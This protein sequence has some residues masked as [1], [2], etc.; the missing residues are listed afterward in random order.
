[1]T[2]NF[3]RAI[4]LLTTL[5]S[6]TALSATTYTFTKI[7]DN[8]AGPFNLMAFQTYILNGNGAV[9]FSIGSEGGGIYIGSGGDVATVAAGAPTYYILTGFN[10]SGTVVYQASGSITTNTANGTPFKVAPDGSGT[11]LPAINNN[12]TVVFTTMDNTVM[13]R[14]GSAA[15]QTLVSNTALPR[16]NQLLAPILYGLGINSAGTVAF[17]GTNVASE[18]SC[19]CGLVLVAP[20][21]NPV[22][23]S[24]K[25]NVTENT[26]LNDSGAVA[27]M[28]IYNGAKG[29]FVAQN[30]QVGAAVD[31]TSQ[32]VSLA[33]QYVSLNNKGEVAYFAKFDISP[34]TQ[35]IFTG[36]DK[37]NDKVIA[38]GDPLF[39]SVVSSIGTSEFGGRFLNDKGQIAFSYVLSNGLRG[40]AVAT[41]VASTTPPPAIS[42]GGIVN[43]ASFASGAPASPGSIVSIFGSNFISQLAVAPGDPL[44]TSLGGVSVT[45]NGTKAPLFFVAPGQI[46]AQVPFEVTGTSATVQVTNAAGQSNTQVIDMAP[47]APAIFTTD[48][49]GIGQAVVVFANSVTIVGPV[50]PGTDWRPAH[51]GDTI[52]IYTNGMGAVTPPINDGWNSCDKSMCAPDFSNLTLRNTSVRPKVTIGGVTVPDSAILY[53]GLVPEFAGLYQINVTIPSGITPGDNVP[54]VIQM[55]D[56]ASP[57]NV[58]IGLQ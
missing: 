11:S 27:F 19:N 55:G 35:G 36:P 31:L 28:G 39:G 58:H 25:Q 38:N 9:A 46:N 16:A 51:T 15:A 18:T 32:L 12:G 40:I 22:L 45:F 10:D 47:A 17:Y 20:G 43:A 3:V 57:P 29:V 44:P 30:G 26:E 37:V 4:V 33:T 6:G 49:N 5:F 2:G 23:T 53:S 34:F 8:G 7:V 21:S 50:K 24:F 56:V 14:T 41:P 1:M 42:S 52:T 54:V 13:T 48:Q